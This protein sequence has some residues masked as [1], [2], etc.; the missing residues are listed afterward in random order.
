MESGSINF[1]TRSGGKVKVPP[2]LLSFLKKEHRFFIATHISPEGDALGSSLALSMVLESL[3]KETVLYEKDVI[4][5]FYGFLPGHEKFTHVIPSIVNHEWPLI[6]LD[7]SSIERAGIDRERKFKLVAVIDHHEPAPHCGARPGTA[8]DFGDIRWI[9]P[10]AAAT[11]LLIFELIKKL[12]VTITK[13]MAI[14]L[15]TAISI[16]TGT[17]RYNNTMSDVLRAGAELIEAGANPASIATNLYETWSRERFALF[18]MALA[19]LEIR[20]DVAFTH[21]TREMY[22]KTGA[23]PEDTEYFSNY[24]RMIKD[25]KVSAFLRELD[26][27]YWKVSLRS[28]GN[29]NVAKIA[30]T[31]NGGGHENA[32]GYEIRASLETAKDLLLKALATAS[33]NR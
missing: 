6:L 24:P 12:G 18:T 31:F 30:S 1:S 8:R 3:G 32:A 26:H 11:G 21:V 20:G 28:K 22:Q 27:D 2:E 29:I 13:D 16:D 15:Y 25:I 10:E 5:E 14:N 19:T 33:A 17:F 4:P 9:V 7:C 23:S